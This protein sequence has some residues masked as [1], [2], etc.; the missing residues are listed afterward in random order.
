MKMK[1]KKSK[2][3]LWSIKTSKTLQLWPEQDKE[4]SLTRPWLPKEYVNTK[5]FPNIKSPKNLKPDFF[6]K[7]KENP[8]N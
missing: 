1:N 2:K 5:K 7:S 4:I 6:K 8:L 3:I